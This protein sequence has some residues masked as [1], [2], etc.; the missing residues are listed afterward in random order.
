MRTDYHRRRDRL[1]ELFRE[2]P[3]HDRIRISEE[4]A[5]L[6]FLIELDTRLGDGE[7]C[8]RAAEA[9]IRLNPLSRYYAGD[10]GGSLHRFIINYSSLDPEIMPRVVEQLYRLLA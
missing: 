8:R 1:L 9:G 10:P 7:I 2:H 6:H 4:D 5:G 3:D